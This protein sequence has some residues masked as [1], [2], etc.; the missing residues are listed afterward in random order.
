[1]L[2]LSIIAGALDFVA[3]AIFPKIGKCLPSGSKN[4]V[5]FARALPGLIELE[6]ELAGRDLDAFARAVAGHSRELAGGDAETARRFD[7]TRV[8]PFPAEA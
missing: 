3:I 4:I 5:D 7:W 1:M 2:A 8:P 6:F